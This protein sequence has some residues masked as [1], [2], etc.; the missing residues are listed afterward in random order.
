MRRSKFALVILY[1]LFGDLS[2]G[3][4][5]KDSLPYLALLKKYDA[6]V[7]KNIDSAFEVINELERLATTNGNNFILSDVLLKKA[8]FY[9]YKNNFEKANQFCLQAIKLSK[10]YNNVKVLLRSQNIAGAI[11]YLKGDF[12]SAEWFYSEK[13]KTAKQI[14]DTTGEMITYYNLGLIYSQTGKYLKSA[15]VNFIAVRYFERIRDTLNL[16]FPL[17]SIG[18]TYSKLDDSPSAIKFLYKAMDLSKRIKE[19]Y[20]LAGIYLDISEEYSK[21]FSLRKDSVEKYLNMALDLTIQQDDAFHRA[22]ALNSKSDY[23]IKCGDYVKALDYGNQAYQLNLQ[24]DNQIG[25]SDNLRNL[26]TVHLLL[27]NYDTCLVYAKKGYS[28]ALKLNQIESLLENSLTISKIYQR[29]NMFDSALKYHQNYFTY[30]STVEKT[31]QLRGMAK[32]ELLFEKENQDILRA[33]EKLIAQTKLEKQK[34]INSI[35]IVASILLSILLVISYINYRQKQKASIEILKQ[36]KLLE[37]KQKEI[38][39]SITYAKRLQEAILP[40][41]EFINRIADNFILYIPKDLVAGDFYWAEN[42]NNLF[43]IAAADSTGHGVPGAMVSVVCSTALNRT[44]KEFGLTEPGKI[45]DK[46]RDL[47]LET[48][49]KSTSEVKDG[50]D[51]SLICIDKKNNKAL[52]SGANNP[53]WYVEDGEL[54]EIKAD[55]QPIGKTEYPKPFT[56]HQIELKKNTVFYLFTDGYADQFGGPNG[57][58]F[59]YK[60]FSDLLLTISNSSQKEQLNSLEQAFKE[61]KGNLEQVDDVCII[62][63]KI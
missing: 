29:K 6:V 35:V 41:T 4:T 15:E 48:F 38:I 9:Y 3:Q 18:I 45:L 8:I 47:V 54:K 56:T 17:Q 26:A 59:K 51:I 63:I 25:V 44:V 40:P 61:W 62:G 21:N 16:I 22:V 33:K 23:F 43:F 49:E 58:K 20:Q 5:K 11:A 7:N 14:N 12:K 60:K 42:I 36:K 13:I 31:S 10:Q 24:T 53:L 55:K 37:E 39:E 1:I 28:S 50:M 2:F 19:Y 27:K 32:K 52:W 46:T 30:Y 57:K 34:Q